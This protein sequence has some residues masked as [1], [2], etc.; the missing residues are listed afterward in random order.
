[1]TKLPA[2]SSSRDVAAFLAKVKS[3]PSVRPAGGTGR[4]IFALDATASRQPMWDHACRL[5]GEMFRATEGL[6]PLHVQLVWYRGLEE[7]DASAF[8]ASSRELVARMTQVS[9]AAG[10][11]Q[12][13]RVLAHT[14]AETRRAKVNA[15]VFVGDAMEENGDRLTQLAGEL[16]LLGVTCF[17]FQEGHDPAARG[18]FERIARLTGGAY[19]PFDAS[20]A[21][22]LRDLLAAVA[23]FAVG[24]RIALVDF[25]TRR[26]GDVLRLMGPLAK[27]RGK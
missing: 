22:L 20:S 4:L 14:I 13:E 18:A 6:G 3:M 17:M 2:Q 26:G 15:L 1:M 7:F 21:D 11:T 9:C 16:G 24:G 10:E 19:F 5:Q 27:P 23:T 12:L 25:A 8:V